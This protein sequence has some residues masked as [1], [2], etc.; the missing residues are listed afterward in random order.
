L[1]LSY[2]GSSG[3]MNQNFQNTLQKYRNP[4]DEAILNINQQTSVL[5]CTALS[6]L[7]TLLLCL[8]LGNPSTD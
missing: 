1:Y 8:Q 7:S 2:L 4:Q 3:K 5:P 6:P